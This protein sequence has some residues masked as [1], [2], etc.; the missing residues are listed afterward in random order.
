MYT[1]LFIIKNRRKIETVCKGPNICDVLPLQVHVLKGES[2]PL[3]PPFPQIRHCYA[4]LWNGKKRHKV[5]LSWTLS[6]EVKGACKNL[7]K[8]LWV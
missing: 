2:G 4:S 3:C 8:D 1:I 6:P 7:Q 5:V